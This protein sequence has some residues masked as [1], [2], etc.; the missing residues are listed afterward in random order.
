MAADFKE[1]GIPLIRI[2]GVKEN[3][4]TLDGCNY[5]DPIKVKEKWEHFKLEIGDL[6]ISCSASRTGLVCEVD[7]KSEGAVPYTGLIRIKAGENV[8][9]IYI[10]YQIQTNFY[11]NQINLLK[12]GSAMEHY[13]PSHLGKVR[14]ICP[15]LSIQQIIAKYLDQ[16]TA[17]INKTI[18]TIQREI[19]LMYDT[20]LRANFRC[21]NWQGRCP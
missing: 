7:K 6:L 10:K 1:S 13:G 19:E 3:F 21:S 4:V 8:D 2:S 16:E 17:K 15:P 12:S 18:S 5:L 14:I 9:K 20:S 11:L